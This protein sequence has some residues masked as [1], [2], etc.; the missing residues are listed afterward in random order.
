V[1]PDDRIKAL[2][3]LEQRIYNEDQTQLFIETPYR[4]GKMIEDILATC[5]PQ[6]KLCIAANLTCEGEYAKTRTVKEW[7][8]KVPDLSKIP[9]IFL[10]YK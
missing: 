6:T 1:K 9:C 7:K 10:L 2:R 4:N 5:R 8:G 3:K